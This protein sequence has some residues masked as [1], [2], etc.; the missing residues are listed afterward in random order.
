MSQIFKQN[1]LHTKDNE[2]KKYSIF[3]CDLDKKG[4]LLNGTIP[5]VIVSNDIGNKFSG[6]ITII[7]IDENKS[8]ATKSSQTKIMN[9]G[10]ALGEEIQTVSKSQI[11]GEKL[12]NINYYQKESVDNICIESLS[13]YGDK[14]K[15]GSI[16]KYSIYYC[17]LEGKESIQRGKRPCVI[18]R[19]NEEV[20]SVTIVPLTSQSKKD[21]P[22]HL[23]IFTPQGIKGIALG[24]QILTIPKES[25]QGGIV[26]F[27]DIK[28]QLMVD[29]ICRVALGL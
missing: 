28:Q 27:V 21:L 17:N 7:P 18:I 13:L 8:M 6:N 24:E 2:I 3:Y 14:K 26:S 22:T 29:K 12:S 4:K 25:V 9:I 1:T 11:V 19:G 23:N 16:K 15:E 20:E 5:C 10:I